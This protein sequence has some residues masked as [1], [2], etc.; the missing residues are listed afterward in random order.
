[1][2]IYIRLILDCGDH[3][4]K[5]I[6]TSSAKSV[7]TLAAMGRQAMIIDPYCDRRLRLCITSFDK[8]WE[9]LARLLIQSVRR[10]S[11]NKNN[12]VEASAVVCCIR[13]RCY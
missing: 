10:D 6:V 3:L 7:P 11:R 12:T 1:M 9:M 5:K 13:N 8:V 2:N 4:T